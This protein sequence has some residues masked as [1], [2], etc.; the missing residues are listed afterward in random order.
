MNKT[1]LL[2]AAGLLLAS[3]LLWL[4]RSYTA[5][6]KMEGFQDEP[7]TPETCRL[8]LSGKEQI[9]KM[10]KTAEDAKDEERINNVKMAIESVDEELTKMGCKF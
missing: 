10:L 5:S 9:L 4:Y 6:I 8:M 1:I 7:A 3:V 2:V